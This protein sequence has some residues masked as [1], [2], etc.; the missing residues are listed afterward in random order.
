MAHDLGLTGH[1]GGGGAQHYL[2]G[3]DRKTEGIQMAEWL[4]EYRGAKNETLTTV[5]ETADEMTATKVKDAGTAA[6]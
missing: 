4:I 3:L 5:I 2:E 6:S 1:P